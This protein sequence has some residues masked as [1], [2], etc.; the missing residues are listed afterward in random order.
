MKLKFFGLGLLAGFATIAIAGYLFVISG[1]MPVPTKSKPLPLEQ[2]IA[3]K[4]IE[5]ATKNTDSI[6]PPFEATEPNL[7][8]GAKLY[9][10]NCAACHGLPTKE[11]NAIAKGMFPPPPQLFNPDE[12]AVGFPAGGIYWIV[13]NGIRLTGMPG[14]E[15]NLTDQQLWQL[16][17]V[18]H[19][20]DKLPPSVLNKLNGIPDPT[21]ETPPVP[22]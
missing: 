21:S 10:T 9:L 14:Y 18:V 6:K 7:L 12:A 17:H 8:E 13:K 1:G 5:V 2:A 22:Q 20:A 15:G 3:E 11:K 4:S 16:T 19:S